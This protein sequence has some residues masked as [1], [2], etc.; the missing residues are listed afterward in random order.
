MEI[1]E[2]TWSLSGILQ[3]VHVLIRL[4]GFQGLKS[5]SGLD[6][7]SSRQALMDWMTGYSNA[8]TLHA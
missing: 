2:G 6:T 4:M 5:Q 7:L 1:P 8:N 3:S